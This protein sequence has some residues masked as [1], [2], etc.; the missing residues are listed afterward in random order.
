MLVEVWHD[1]EHG[2]LH[3]GKRIEA[4]LAGKGYLYYRIDE[5]RGPLR[6]WHIGKPGSGYSNYFLCTE[7]AARRLEL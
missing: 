2:N 6:E 1:G 7:A 4:A 5:Q 3:M